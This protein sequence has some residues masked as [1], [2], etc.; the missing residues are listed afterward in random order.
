MFKLARDHLMEKGLEPVAG[1]ISPVNDAYGKASLIPGPLR[2][3]M[4]KLAVKDRN[5]EGFLVVDPWEVNQER[6]VPTIEALLHH[7][8]ILRQ[9]FQTDNVKLIMLSGA[10]LF[11][12]LVAP[13][14]WKPEHVEEILSNFGIAVV[15]RHS[16][17]N[18]QQFIASHPV[19]S[20]HQ[21]NIFLVPAMLPSDISSTLVRNRIRSDEPIDD[22]VP[23][24]VAQ[25][26]R[27]NNIYK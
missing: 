8:H 10:D 25:F 21:K 24:S 13:G 5:E 7:L 15:D 4:C 17:V 16:G 19:L 20:A 1:I 26:I 11:Q 12:S 23:S 18:L 14:V 22:L 3:Q 6:F 9:E 2:C 27:D